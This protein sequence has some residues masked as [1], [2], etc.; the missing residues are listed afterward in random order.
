LLSLLAF[1][2]ERPDPL[3][4]HYHL[5]NGYRQF[6]PVLMR[7]NS[8][9]SLSPFSDGGLNAYA[10]CVGDP[11]N[12]S[13]PT[14]KISILSIITGV[15][16]VVGAATFVG[17]LLVEDE[18]LA[19]TLSG[20]SMLASGIAIGGGLASL[21]KT[22]QPQRTGSVQSRGNRSASIP[23]EMDSLPPRDP[24]LPPAYFSKEVSPPAPGG[25]G[26]DRF[27]NRQAAY[28]S[29]AQNPNPDLSRYRPGGRPNG[30]PASARSL[31]LIDD[32]NPASFAPDTRRS[33]ASSLASNSSSIRNS[34]R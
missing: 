32:Q 12:R 2:G 7:F 22:R 9:D 27:S 23:M 4:G 16:G 24:G 10:Y 19:W 5:G 34:S 18:T 15:S 3:T 25:L 29:Q 11:V 8:S 26:L 30:S 13:D 31:S 1:N 14:G 33:S 6:N 17:S 21:R 28:R 20:I